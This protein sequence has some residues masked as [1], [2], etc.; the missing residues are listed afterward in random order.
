MTTDFPRLR[1]LLAAALLF[2]AAAPAGAT[3]YFVRVTGSD[4]SAGTSPGTA[5]RTVQRAGEAARAGDTVY[6]GAGTYTESVL[7]LADGTAGSV[8]L[9]VADTDGSRT[10]DAGTVTLRPANGGSIALRLDDER[11]LTFRGF[12]FAAN[13][14]GGD[15]AGVY[16]NDMDNVRFESCEFANFVYYGVAGEG[17][18]VAVADCTFD[19]VLAGVAITNGEVT[20]TGSSFAAKDGG[21]GISVLGSELTVRDCVF[22]GGGY[23][24]NQI[25]GPS[26]LI[27]NC[28]ITDATVCG[29]WMGGEDVRIDACEFVGCAVGLNL[30]AA[31]GLEPHITDTVI[32]DGETGI[33]TALTG[34]KARNTTI[35]GHSDT[36]LRIAPDNSS[37]LVRAEDTV[38]CTGNTIGLAWERSSSGG[39][40]TVAGQTWADNGDHVL[41]NRISSVD[42]RDCAF[43]GGANGVFD[44]NG[45]SLTVRDCTFRDVADPAGQGGVRADCPTLAVSGCLFER[46]Y[47]GLR[48]R[49]A[50]DPDVRDCTFRDSAFAGMEIG[51]GS[52]N[53]TAADNLT[54]VGNEYGVYATRLDLDVDG[55]AAGIEIVGPAT[56]GT[57]FYAFVGAGRTLS[58]R[59]FRAT[60][61]GIGFRL[62]SPHGATLEDCS[63]T[64]CSAYGVHITHDSSNPAPVAA[65]VRNFTAAGCVNGLGYVRGSGVP[66]GQG[67]IELR[68]ITAT[69]PVAVDGDGYPAA[70][71]GTG[72]YLYGC[73]LDPAHHSDLTVD[74]YHNGFYV[75]DA[76]ANLT[77]AMNVDPSRCRNGLLVVA[78]ALTATGYVSAATRYALYLVPNYN[79]ITLNDCDLTA[80]D[81]AVYVRNGGDL[82]ADG[83]T[84]EGRDF[85]GV[86]YTS[87]AAPSVTLTNCT[88]TAAGDGFTMR[89]GGAGEVAFTDCTVA[90]AGDDGFDVG[91][92]DAAPGTAT[93]DRCHVHAADDDGFRSGWAAVTCRDCTVAAAGDDGFQFADGPADVTGCA[94]AAAD[95]DG[96][97]LRECP[98]S[99]IAGCTARGCGSAGVYFT[100]GTGAEVVNL[101]V[102][103]SPR[104]VLAESTGTTTL[105]HA[106][107]A[108]AQ[109]AMKV[110][111]GN[112]TVR[113][114]VL[115]GGDD[116]CNR[117]GGTVAFDH[118]L[119]HAP[120]PYDGATPGPDDILKAPLFRDP[121]AGDYRLAEGSP[122]IN[123]GADLSGI[124]DFDLL[125]VARPT[126]RRHD[127]GA[128]EYAEAEGSLRILDWRERAE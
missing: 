7:G 98:A 20:A 117:T 36:G 3:D 121:A 93:F 91:F 32:R 21:F 41:T 35:S 57:G 128:Y 52:W 100:E 9:W 110:T 62:Q 120:T 25:S 81:R 107:L 114:S 102:T 82:T 64:D 38:T 47:N 86:L 29:A 11:H 71:V 33:Y 67:Q 45:G 77:A 58:C 16:G 22:N 69:K 51:Y 2:A 127:L 26:P 10:G 42:V 99:A 84:F 116:G 103:D 8:I 70:T 125:G 31:G 79:S 59:N 40:L 1:A 97:D 105:T 65:V 17:S 96:F 4:T 113:N 27:E 112:V 18:T 54:F 78:G 37:F 50:V 118:V 95:E 60:S 108:A 119:L 28:T 89:F 87:N 126:H 123:A 115:V 124:V 101:L 63:A 111:A 92:S 106:T 12:R 24:I 23:G 83:C 56:G 104:A 88:A 39:T 43:T 109:D 46:C 122:A 85:D 15:T 5:F 55:G 61:C 13:P 72:V 68:G 66:A 94:V 76:G 6:V 90:A 19:D 48:V 74:G 49:D 14:S 53:W 75:R 30:P 44:D 80:S 34:L 73:P